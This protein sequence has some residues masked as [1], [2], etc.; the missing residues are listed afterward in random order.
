MAGGREAS[1]LTPSDA[2]DTGIRVG[3]EQVSVLIF[4]WDLHILVSGMGTAL[5][6]QD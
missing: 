4:T 3:T 1:Q 6:T 2:G 5:V